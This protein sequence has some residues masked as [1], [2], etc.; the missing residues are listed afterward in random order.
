MGTVKARKYAQ[1]VLDSSV[2]ALEAFPA[3]GSILGYTVL[4]ATL[5]VARDVLERLD[6]DEPA[7]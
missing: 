2:S 4:C 5:T 6:E 3:E 7:T 1:H